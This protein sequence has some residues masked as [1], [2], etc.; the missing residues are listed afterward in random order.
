MKEFF[1][2][3]FP[4]DFNSLIVWGSLIIIAFV[5]GFILNFDKSESVHQYEHQHSDNG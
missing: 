5:L 3:T 1:K 4:Q 2:K